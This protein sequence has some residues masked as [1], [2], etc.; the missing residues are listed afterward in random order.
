MENLGQQAQSPESTKANKVDGSGVD[1]GFSVDQFRADLGADTATEDFS[2]LGVGSRPASSQANDQV[3]GALIEMTCIMVSKLAV[4][5]T[6]FDE[7]GL[8]DDEV[9]QLVELWRPFTPEMSPLA[10][11]VLGTTMIV[12]SKTFLY[13]QLRKQH[14]FAELTSVGGNKDDESI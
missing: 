7:I 10:M 1:G 14:K 2:D 12:S 5:L 11:A 3:N 4:A 13:L 8:D 6:G 9:S